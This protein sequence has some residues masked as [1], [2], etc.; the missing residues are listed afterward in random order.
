MKTTINDYYSS[1][2]DDAQQ[3]IGLAQ[4]RLRR[5]REMLAESGDP[6][7]MLATGRVNEI[8]AKLIEAKSDID[9]LPADVKP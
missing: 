8:E 7:R 9:K 1:L 6:A 3:F 4:D 5:A 2:C